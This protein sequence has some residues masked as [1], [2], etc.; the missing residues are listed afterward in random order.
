M[1]TA[2]AFSWCACLSIGALSWLAAGIPGTLCLIVGMII[3]QIDVGWIDALNEEVEPK[4]LA[5]TPT[6]E[7]PKPKRRRRRRFSNVV[8]FPVRRV[9]Q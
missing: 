8:P 7:P 2:E 1:T 6:N 4:P 5:V 3:S 9:G